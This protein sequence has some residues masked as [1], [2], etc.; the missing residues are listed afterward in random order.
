[1]ARADQTPGIRPRATLGR[2]L[3]IAARHSFPTGCTVLLMLLTEAP[4]GFADQATLLPAVTLA[5]VYFWS[6][7]RPAA[8]PPPVVFLLG[9]LFDL[10]GYMP[11]GVGPLTLLAV[12]GLAL[13]WRRVLT[14]QGFL[15]AWLAFAGFATGA[16]ALGWILTAALSFRLLPVGPAL[17]E[18]ALTAALYPALAILFIRAHRTVAD[19]ERA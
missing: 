1:M 4:F 7:F 8:M 6:L 5:C 11:L 9:L 3:D 17:F 18:A 12:Y 13:R 19:P 15:S 16:A 2:R 10:L 14:R